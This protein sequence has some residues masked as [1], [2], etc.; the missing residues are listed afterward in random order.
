MCVRMVRI[1]ATN[2]MRV[3]LL[4]VSGNSKQEMHIGANHFNFCMLET[5]ILTALIKGQWPDTLLLGIQL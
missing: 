5:F 4:Y 1:G 3:L 2:E